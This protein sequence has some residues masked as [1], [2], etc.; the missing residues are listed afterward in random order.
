MRNRSFMKF[1]ALWM[2]LLWSYT[3][4]AQL[5]IVSGS[6]NEYNITPKGLL[7][8]S[9]MN[10]QHAVGVILEAKL[11]DLQTQTTLLDVTSNSFML[12]QGL[13]N[14]SQLSVSVASSVYSNGEKVNYLKSTHSLPS[15]NYK[16]CIT[17]KTL[18]IDVSGDEYCSNLEAE[19]SRFLFLVSPPDKD[20]IST[21]FPVLIWTHS[22]PF[23]LSNANNYYKMVVTELNPDQ[24]PEAAINTNVPVYLKNYLSS[25]SVQ[26]PVDAKELIEGKSYAWQVEQINN[27]NIVNKTEAWQ[28]KLRPNLK[29]PDIKFVTVKKN[30]DGAY[31]LAVNNKIY[32]RF[33]ESYGSK[34]VSYKIYNEQHQPIPSNTNQELKSTEV[35]Y[36]EYEINLAPFNLKQGMYLLEIIN[37]KKE[38]YSLKFLTE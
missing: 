18:S 25:H 36:N 10:P 23:S 30:V 15:G 2:T 33:D 21:K 32:F 19:A 31:Y 35:G 38:V 28:F 12:K 1:F 3:A 29:N 16:Y 24:S 37:D 27:G 34:K 7:E 4:F 8:V 13:S 26:Y 14:T 17:V 5:S 11:I 20:E 22:E 9:I 6:V